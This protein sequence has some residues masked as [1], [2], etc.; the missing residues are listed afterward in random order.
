M[1]DPL[2]IA[3]PHCNTTNHVPTERTGDKPRCSKC[4]KP[5]FDGHPVELDEAVLYDSS[6]A[7]Y[8][9]NRDRFLRNATGTSGSTSRSRS[10]LEFKGVSYQGDFL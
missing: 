8:C 4:H 5:L 9:T 10:I 2:H 3:C 1:S 7:K 6:F